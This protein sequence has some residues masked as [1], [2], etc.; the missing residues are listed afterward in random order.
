MLRFRRWAE[1]GVWDGMLPTLVD[2]GLTHD[3][4]HMI[5]STIVRGRFGS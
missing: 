4:Q 5:D 2:L 1:Q 3:G